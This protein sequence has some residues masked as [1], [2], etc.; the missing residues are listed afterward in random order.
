MIE[1]INPIIKHHSNTQSIVQLTIVHEVYLQDLVV[2]LKLLL[3]INNKDMKTCF[4]ILIKIIGI[5]IMLLNFL[6]YSY[7]HMKI[8]HM[9]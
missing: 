6:R 7:N 9:R 5:K 8:I 1:S 4:M 3:Q 2:K